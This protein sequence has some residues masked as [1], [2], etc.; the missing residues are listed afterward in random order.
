MERRSFLKYLAGIATVGAT[1]ILSFKSG[2]GQEAM[3][4]Q[5]D[6]LVI[7][8]RNLEEGSEYPNRRTHSGARPRNYRPHY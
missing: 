1:Q 8:A 7:A 5:I 6:D 3:Q 2:E 4:P